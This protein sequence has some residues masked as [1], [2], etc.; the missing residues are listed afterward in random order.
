MRNPSRS[1][2]YVAATGSLALLLATS[3]F[4]EDR[5]RDETWHS[6][7]QG[8]TRSWNRG[9]SRGFH[10]D[11]QQQRTEPRTFDRGETRSFDQNRDRTWDRGRSFD[12][13][14]ASDRGQARS[15]DQGRTWDR[16]Q[17]RSFDQGR[18]WNRG[19]GTRNFDQNFNRNDRGWDS[20]R[21]DFRGE[22]RGDFRGSREVFRNGI[23]RS[24][25]RVTMLGHISRYEHERGGYRIWF[26]GSLYPYW[27]PESYFFRHRI[28]IGLDLRLGGIF[29][30]GAVYV[31]YLGWPGDA[32]YNDPYYYDAGYANGY[33]NGYSASVGAYGAGAYDE[34]FV[35]G[36]VDSIDYR[37]GTLYLRDDYSRRV[38]TVDMRRVDG[39]S[40]SV[41]FG[42]LRPG[43]RVS[44]RG[45]W[46]DGNVFAAA[47]LEGA[48]AY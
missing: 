40:S 1:A 29:R 26:G 48:G 13:G 16:G 3:A 30:D 46:L 14:R 28:G 25:G 24:D 9:D 18:T 10:Q 12:Q 47:R 36:T 34:G 2:V 38:I 5:H 31:N 45:A 41:D 20:R 42:D 4:A 21:G 23:P 22:F 33:A 11:H 37:T 17:A 6:H 8:P 19:G 39:R 27:V 7:E 43:D 35:R 32:Y 44:L 15:F